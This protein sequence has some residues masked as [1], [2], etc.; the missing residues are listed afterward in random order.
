MMCVFALAFGCGSSDGDG[1]NND[2]GP[3]D[4]RGT[5]QIAAVLK[6]REKEVVGRHELRTVVLDGCCCHGPGASGVSHWLGANGLFVR[7]T[8]PQHRAQRANT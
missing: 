2:P 6:D 7:F 5:A 3:D 1:I 8:A 4:F